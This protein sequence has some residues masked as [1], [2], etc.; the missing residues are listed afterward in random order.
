[1]SITAPHAPASA[2]PP[3]AVA[4][5]TL[6]TSRSTMLLQGDYTRKSTYEQWRD[7]SKER[8]SRP[9]RSVVSIRGAIMNRSAMVSGFVLLSAIAIA[10]G[11]AGCSAKTP[12]GTGFPTTNGNPAEGSSSG[13]DDASS[14]SP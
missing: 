7:D 3:Y 1:M 9:Q 14:G 8:K 12:T 11:F 6:G 2:P 13:A 4:R 10:L 5:E